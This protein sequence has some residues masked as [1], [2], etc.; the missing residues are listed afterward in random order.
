[1]HMHIITQ[2]YIYTPRTQMDHMLK[3]LTHKME[4]QPLT[5]Y[6]QNLLNPCRKKHTLRA[7]FLWYI[8]FFRKILHDHSVWHRNR[9]I[10]HEPPFNSSHWLQ[11]PYRWVLFK[12]RRWSKTAVRSGIPLCL[13]DISHL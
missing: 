9:V 13:G 2:L 11:N 8:N 12:A 1:M 6:E 10:R 5:I 3:D 4:G 7:M